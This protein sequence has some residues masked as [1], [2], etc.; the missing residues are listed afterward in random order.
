MREFRKRF[1]F[2]SIALTFDIPLTARKSHENRA[3]SRR[4]RMYQI[5]FGNTIAVENLSE[6]SR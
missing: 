4:Y 2:S 3:I 6:E 1:S 5:E